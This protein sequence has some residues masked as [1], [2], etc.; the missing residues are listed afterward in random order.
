MNHAEAL[1]TKEAKRPQREAFVAGVI[2]GALEDYCG[3]VE[4]GDGS[5]APFVVEWTGYEMRRVEAA[6][7]AVP[8]VGDRYRVVVTEEAHSG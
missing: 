1:A 7:N 3:D 8:N 4:V 2:A 5:S 6:V